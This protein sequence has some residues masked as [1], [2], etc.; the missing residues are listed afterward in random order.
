MSMNKEELVS[1]LKDARLTVSDQTAVKGIELYPEW[2]VGIEITQEMIDD[3]QN[4]Y[5]CDGILWRTGTPHTTQENWR[6]SIYTASLW[7]AF[8]AD[9]AGTIEDPIPV[10]DQLVSFEYEWGKYYSE[11]GTLYICD[12]PGGKSGDKYTLDYKPS[13]L[14]GHYFSVVN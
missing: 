12:R 8:N 4:R 3:G 9:H 7:T 11:S 2:A 10:P 5:R 14:I 13:A 1:Y 6:P